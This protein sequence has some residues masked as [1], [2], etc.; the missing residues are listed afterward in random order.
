VG[1]F[2]TPMTRSREEIL[3]PAIVEMSRGRPRAA[4]RELELAR[5]ELTENG[6]A[7]G[8]TRVLGLARQVSTLAPVDA[9]ARDRLIEETERALGSLPQTVGASVAPVSAPSPNAPG[10]GGYTTDQ[11]LAPVLAAIDR[12]ETGGALRELE[13]ARRR[14]LASGNIDGLGE[15]IE[16]ARRLPVSKPRHERS[17]LLVIDA[18]EQNVRFLL[19]CAALGAGR[20]W[21]DPFGPGAA[22]R[23]LPAL[24][25]M[26]RHEKLVS[27]AVTVILVAAVAAL[28][29]L[30]R[31]AS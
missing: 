15:L 11:I 5:R 21:S 24:P 22:E 20:A 12:H 1:D 18:A 10:H 13:A 14:L 16:V 7:D 9:R 4:L 28:A 2:R 26:T 3:A 6:D 30:D 23:R 8:L 31:F 17:R 29:I 27:V 19:R 25:P